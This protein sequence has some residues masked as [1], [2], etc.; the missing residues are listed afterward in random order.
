MDDRGAPDPKAMD[1][2]QC[3][4]TRPMR[5]CRTRGRGKSRTSPIRCSEN[6][7]KGLDPMPRAREESSDALG[8][9]GYPATDRQLR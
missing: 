7:A 8:G 4:P 9:V 1:D 6:I 5:K 2:Q 3:S